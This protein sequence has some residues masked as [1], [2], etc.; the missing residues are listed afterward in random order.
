MHRRSLALL[1]LTFLV[2]LAPA[3]GAFLNNDIG[4]TTELVDFNQFD[5]GYVVMTSNPVQVFQNGGFAINMNV[6][7]AA[8]STNTAIYGFGGPADYY[9]VNQTMPGDPVA[10]SV[11]FNL[12][13]GTV[14]SIGIRLATFQSNFHTPIVLE[15]FDTSD[16]LLESHTF[17]GWVGSGSSELSSGGFYGFDTGTANIA[18]MR[19]T[20][21]T[22]E[23]DD[24]RFGGL[25]TGGQ[26]PDPDPSAVPEASTF[27]LCASALGLL[28]LAG[29]F[30]RKT[31]S[32][33]P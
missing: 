17:S 7:N 26:D 8:D 5:S 3:Y 33:K 4:S 11:E 14:S 20:G 1:A 28:S 22:I 27:L 10:L 30:R 12:A 6:P 29:R 24:L 2:A 9:L 13:G 16:L 23:L 21:G 18:R 25:S 19:I 32:P 31:G 15:I